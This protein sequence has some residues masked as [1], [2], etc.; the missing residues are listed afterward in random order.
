MLIAFLISFLNSVRR[1]IVE[2]LKIQKLKPELNDKM[3]LKYLYK[4]DKLSVFYK[5]Y[6][7]LVI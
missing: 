6:S 2:A 7:I 3:E 1:K 5:G 4:C